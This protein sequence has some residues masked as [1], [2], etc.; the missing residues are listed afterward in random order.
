[1]NEQTQTTPETTQQRVDRERA[2]R[3]ALAEKTATEL[4]AA[5]TDLTRET[6]TGTPDPDCYAAR[7]RVLRNR[8][9]LQLI[10][11]AFS[12]NRQGRWSVHAAS[13]RLPNHGAKEGELAVKAENL[14][15]HARHGTPERNLTIYLSRAKPAAQIARDIA[16]RLL[17]L[18]D[19][20]AERATSANRELKARLDWLDTTERELRAQLPYPL[21]AGA[22][23]RDG[24][25]ELHTDSYRVQVQLHAYDRSV[26]IQADGLTPAT[27]AAVL[28]ALT[29]ATIA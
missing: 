24:N 27:A 19:M 20:L 9:G 6:W 2:E 22:T 14:A 21:T 15:A 29:P 10:V 17:P 28:I 11:A 18:A 12:E 1:M 3:L 26:K 13:V 7:V 25:R 5:L 4:G 16:R 23:Q 8:D